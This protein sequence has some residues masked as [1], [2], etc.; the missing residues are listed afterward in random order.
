MRSY[1][2]DPDLKKLI[3]KYGSDRIGNFF[4]N[5]DNKLCLLK[6]H[7]FGDFLLLNK[8]YKKLYGN[9]ELVLKN[10]KT[11]INVFNIFSKNQTYNLNI[12]SRLTERLN[13][14]CNNSQLI[15]F[16]SIEYTISDEIIKQLNELFDTNNNIPDKEAIE[17]SI[18]EINNL[19]SNILPTNND[20]IKLSKLFISNKKYSDTI[21]ENKIKR[22]KNIENS[23]VEIKNDYEGRKEKVREAN[24]EIV[25]YL[26]YQDIIIQKIS[27]IQEIYKNLKFESNKISKNSD[28]P[29]ND[30]LEFFVEIS[31]IALLQIA[32][33]VQIDKEYKTAIEIIKNKFSVVNYSSTSIYNEMSEFLKKELNYINKEYSTKDNENFI[34]NILF[35]SKNVFKQITDFTYL[36]NKLKLLFDKCIITINKLKKNN[37]NDDFLKRLDYVINYFVNRKETIISQLGDLNK[38][39]KNSNIENFKEIKSEYF[40]YKINKELED[41][42][43]NTNIISDNNKNAFYNLKD[44]DEFKIE[45]DKL[46]NELNIINANLNLNDK[47]N[48]DLQKSDLDY[49]KKFYTSDTER[50]IHDKI[51]NNN[52]NIGIDINL[53]EDVELF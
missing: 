4:S 21:I 46:I 33:L 39:S 25:K 34:E 14:I 47:G 52:N 50:I 35:E 16:N 7:S 37:N 17:N 42:K 45:F 51:V 11:I 53:N 12:I 19:I 6:E 24:S 36:F 44:Y 20:I 10:I 18:V 27:H 26:Q 41:C 48:I 23:I 49:L 43:K 2:I 1:N 29:V 15:D 13:S 40:I 9:S 8:Y 28:N 32:Q 31:D 30:K 5:I 38:L 3:N 22:L